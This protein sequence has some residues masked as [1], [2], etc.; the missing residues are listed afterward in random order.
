MSRSDSRPF[1][2]P[3]ADGL[4]S[5]SRAGVWF[6]GFA[7]GIDFIFDGASFT[8]IGIALRGT[9]RSMSYAGV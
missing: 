6:I 8:A 4:E 9:P 2:G 3:I 5:I 1:G 7:I